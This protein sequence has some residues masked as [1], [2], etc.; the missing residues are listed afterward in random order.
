[1]RLQL[2]PEAAAELEEATAWYLERGWDLADRFVSEVER[3]MGL[4]V[5]N[6][7]AWTELESGIRRALLRGFPYSLIYSI[8][9]GTIFVLAVM[10]QKR[11]PGYWRHRR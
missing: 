8:E 3:T 4:V 10:H 9:P 5:E 1:M 6:P 2:G 7:H 11:R